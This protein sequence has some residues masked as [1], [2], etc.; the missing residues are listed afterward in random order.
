[1]K[2]FSM[3]VSVSLTSE[4]SW[5][6]MD[7]P[8]QLPK[9]NFGIARFHFAIDDVGANEIKL[10]EAIGV[11]ARQSGV[12]ARRTES[13]TTL[14]ESVE[15][16]LTIE[17]YLRQ[18][19]DFQEVADMILA[20][21]I[22]HGIP[23]SNETLC[24]EVE[25][26]ISASFS[27]R[28][29]IG[30]EL[31]VTATALLPIVNQMPPEF[32]GTIVSAAAYQKRDAHL[33]LTHVDY[34]KVE[35]ERRRNGVRRRATSK[36]LFNGSGSPP[37]QMEVFLHFATITYWQLMPKI[38]RFLAQSDH[39]EPLHDPTEIII[40]APAKKRSAADDFPE[41]ATLYKIAR[42]AFP[43]KWILRRSPKK[44]W[45]EADLIAIELD[46]VRNKSSWWTMYGGD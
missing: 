3:P 34:L 20:R 30:A 21:M 12:N 43:R 18:R 31:K 5:K 4:D 38:S 13:E 22:I 28:E 17:K 26:R 36:P 32:E 25:H 23:H 42:A 39:T 6:N 10:G 37:N 11:Y 41:V 44:E 19:K 40:A 46:E 45:T 29:Q 8:S 7:T 24:D 16:H 1:M 15:P 2:R 9:T 27:T 35:F 33:Y 14:L